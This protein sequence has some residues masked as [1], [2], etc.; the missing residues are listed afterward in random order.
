MAGPEIAP[1]PATRIR[2]S[3]GRVGPAAGAVPGPAGRVVAPQGLH[4]EAPALVAGDVPERAR[5]RRR[6]SLG[7][8]QVLAHP[9][10]LVAVL[11]GVDGV[12]PTTDLLSAG[13]A[14]DHVLGTRIGV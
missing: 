7:G 8:E 14:A 11:V 4:R 2:L 1:G 10:A 5:D 3:R 9:G 13:A 6:G 12:V